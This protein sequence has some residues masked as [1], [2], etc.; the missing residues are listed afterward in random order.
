MAL[1][2]S[3]M[4]INCRNKEEIAIFREIAIAEGHLWVSGRNLCELFDDAKAGSFQIGYEEN[5]FPRD[6]TF[7]NKDDDEG[8]CFNFVGEYEYADTMTV[9]EASDLFRNHIISRRLKHGQGMDTK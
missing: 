8:D 2:K 6:V 7:Y 1:I 4:S 9:I 3:G 5:Q